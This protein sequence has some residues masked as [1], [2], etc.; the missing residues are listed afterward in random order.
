MQHMERDLQQLHNHKAGLAEMRPHSPAL[1]SPCGVGGVTDALRSGAA[2]QAGRLG[3]VALFFT[4][5]LWSGFAAVCI[6]ST[7]WYFLSEK[8]PFES[9][10]N[11]CQARQVIVQS[12]D[13]AYTEFCGTPTNDYLPIACAMYW[14]TA[15]VVAKTSCGSS[16]SPSAALCWLLLRGGVGSVGC[17]TGVWSAGQLLRRPVALPPD[18]RPGG[19]D[20]GTVPTDQ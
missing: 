3:R 8:G 1:N 9:G 10:P 15:V 16:I 6:Q 5:K 7:G 2:K 13:D 20:S 14:L 4:I 17:T 12:L 11:I 19:G 18:I